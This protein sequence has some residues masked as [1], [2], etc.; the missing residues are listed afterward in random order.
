MSRKIAI[1]IDVSNLYYCI[2]K[3]FNG[4]KLNYQK[5]YDYIAGF[6]KVTEAL[7]YGAQNNDEAEVFIGRLKE[8]GF[9]PVYKK[10]KIY[11]D[12]NGNKKSKADWDVAMAV[13]LLK[14]VNQVD[15]V[16]LGTADGDLA[17]AVSEAMSRGL[18]VIVMACIISRDLRDAATKDVEIPESLLER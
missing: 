17:P 11:Y 18:H 4:K 16:V 15:L 10:P 5:Y 13:K 1:L 2:K 9:T 8:I 3:K 6:G 12:K 7:A 14:L